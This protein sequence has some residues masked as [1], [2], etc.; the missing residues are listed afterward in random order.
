MPG[1]VVARLRRPA[2]D[3]GIDERRARLGDDVADLDLGR[4]AHRVAI[5][6]DRLV[7]ARPDQRRHLLGQRQRVARRQDRQEI[8]GARQLLVGH[9]DHAGG[10]GPLGAGLAAAGERRDHPQAPLHQPPADAGAHGALCN[11]RNCRIHGVIPQ[12]VSIAIIAPDHAGGEF[13]ERKARLRRRHHRRRPVRADARHRARPPRR[14]DHRAGGKDLAGAVSRPPTPPRP[15]PWSTTG[16]WA[17][18]R[19]SA[20]R[21]CRPTIRPTSPISPAT[22]STSWRASACRRRGRRARWSRR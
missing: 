22:P 18:P 17:L 11:H 4:R 8:V 14:L 1:P 13:R 2:D 9:R 19:R 7:V 21:A 3:A 6:I 16:G 20:P 5:D 15:A 12:I 10:L